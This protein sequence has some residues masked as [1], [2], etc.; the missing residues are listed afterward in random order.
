MGYDILSVFRI[1]ECRAQAW[2]METNFAAR[3]WVAL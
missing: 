3:E 2:T 1:G